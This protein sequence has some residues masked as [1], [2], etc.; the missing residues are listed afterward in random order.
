MGYVENY[1]YR[2]ASENFKTLKDLLTGGDNSSSDLGQMAEWDS[3]ND[4]SGGVST[5]EDAPQGS[6]IY[7]QIHGT[8]FSGLYPQNDPANQT[9]SGSG[10]TQ[11]P[12]AYNGVTYDPN[13]PE[14]MQAYY[15]V[16]SGEIDKQLTDA[17]KQGQF[18]FAKQLIDY[19]TEWDQ[20]G[21]DLAS[22]Y[23]QGMT[24]R[25]QYFQGLGSRAYQS[26]MGTSGQFALNQLGE[27]QNQRNTDLNSNNTSMDRAYNDWINQQQQ[28][29]QTS[30]DAL[31]NSQPGMDTNPALA[32]Y[33]PAAPTKTDISQYTP[34]TTFSQL[35]GSAQ[36][37]GVSG[38]SLS[39]KLRQLKD[40][41]AWNINDYM[42]GKG[43][44]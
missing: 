33:T 4:Q 5:N 31:L 7:D 6:G 22:G 17:L 30:R 35:A 41:N 32:G 15:A 38:V 42:L 36:P 1:I 20:Q 21:K 19:K 16:R 23:S 43:G 37:A 11:Q 24:N 18:D 10:T 12:F 9:S 44:V 34:Y 13:S 26:S 40:P 2:P 28:T 8:N 14:D 29:T 25:Q 39:E 3:S 27:A